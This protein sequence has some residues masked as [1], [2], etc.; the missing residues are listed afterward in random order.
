MCKIPE[1]IRNKVHVNTWKRHM[2][3]SQGEGFA[4]GQTLPVVPGHITNTV[5]LMLCLKRSRLE[6]QVGCLLFSYGNSRVLGIL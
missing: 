6:F 5:I 4:G 1:A 2:R 3:K